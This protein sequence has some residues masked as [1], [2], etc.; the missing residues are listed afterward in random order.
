MR[1]NAE[2]MGIKSAIDDYFT[3]AIDLDPLANLFGWRS[4]AIVQKYSPM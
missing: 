4:L 2:S 1:C 3:Y